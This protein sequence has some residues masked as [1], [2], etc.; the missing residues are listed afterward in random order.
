[1]SDRTPEGRY[2]NLRTTSVAHHENA[3]PDAGSLEARAAL[4]L[5]ILAAIEV[6]GMVLA[7]F[8]PTPPVSMFHTVMFNL[9][10]G[11][12][13][14]LFVTEA[15]G[16]DRSRPWAVATARPLLLLVAASGTYS[17]VAG[18]GSGRIVLPFELGLAAWAWLGPRDLA[19]HARWDRRT[20]ALLGAAVAL[21]LSMSFGG[22]L[23]AWGGAFDVHEP[24]LKAALHVDCGPPTP[25][26]PPT[27]T[28]GYDWSWTSTSP[29][30]SGLDIVVV[31]WTGVDG[32]GRPLYVLDKAPE[33]GGGIHPGLRDYPSLALADEIGR[34]STG[35]WQWG[36]QLSE[37]GLRPGHFDAQL[38][39]TRDV[40]PGP[41]TLLIK[42]SYVHLGL[43]RHDVATV[44]C[45]W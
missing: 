43:W 42:A 21:V 20:I 38:V 31:G 41:K 34:E 37:Q 16:L 22:K 1:M 15:R 33:P 18:L 30:P 39:R 25:G 36:I 35:S 17:V 11:A 10:A 26:S 45:A 12:L 40:R 5:K 7:M 6:G 2:D 8:P 29:L 44:T 14:V 13:A 23:F 24:D 9:A 4:A 28:L 27:I 3:G 32:A 19:Q